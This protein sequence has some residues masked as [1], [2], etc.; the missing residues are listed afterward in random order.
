MSTPDTS[1][2]SEPT[3]VQGGTDTTTETAPRP[4]DSDTELAPPLTSSMGSARSAGQD[5]TIGDATT[6]GQPPTA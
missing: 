2:T 6:V 1:A 4:R 5:E 3:V